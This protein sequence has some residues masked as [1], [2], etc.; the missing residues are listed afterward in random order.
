MIVRLTGGLGNQMF[1]YAFGRSLSMQRY[2]PLKFVWSRSTWD[3]GLDA[4]NTRIELVN[5]P[6]HAPV[7]E[8]PGF[9]YDHGVMT[10]LKGSYY[11]GY[12]QSPKYFSKYADEL[13]QELTPKVIRPE[14]KDRAS[15][16]RAENSV[17]VH[18]RRGDYT[19]PGTKDFH[20]LMP[21]EYY[22]EAQNYLREKLNKPT[23]YYF[24]DDPKW[25]TDNLYIDFSLGEQVLGGTGNLHED[26]YLMRNCRHGIGAN[27]TFS[28][29]GNWL[30]EHPD[31]VSIAPKKWFTNESI[32]TADLIPP[33]WIR[34]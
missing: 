19:N 11:K 29:F 20:G 5:P 31:R 10:S 8:E 21:S 4:Y 34:L 32:D 27:S 16:L 6:I 12:W 14:V 22:R 26:L 28:W 25:V 18:V 30:G 13:R 23:F 3:Y 2:D 1:Q 17:F 7:Y 9:A 24:S 15:E 33:H